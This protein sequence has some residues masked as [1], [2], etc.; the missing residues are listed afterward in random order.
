MATLH[1]DTLDFLD[2]RKK[3]R[4]LRIKAFVRVQVVDQGSAIKFT[5]SEGVA[6]NF[7]TLES[8]P[9]VDLW[10]K[11]RE[12]T[13]DIRTPDILTGDE[14]ALGI[15][16]TG[17]LQKSL[18][19]VRKLHLPD[20]ASADVEALMVRQLRL[21]ESWR[22]A[23]LSSR[24][25]KVHLL[26]HYAEQLRQEPIDELLWRQSLLRPFQTVLSSS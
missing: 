24:Q 12:K 17:D 3:V 15:P 7:K 8:H 11:V 9:Y 10:D 26:N 5:N 20:A 22:R 21:L 14:P 23:R 19:D 2:A 25:R 6:E 13:A 16:W 1:Q 18:L 4:A